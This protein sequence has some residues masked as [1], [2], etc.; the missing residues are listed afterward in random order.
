MEVYSEIAV[1][2]IRSQEE[3]IGPVAIEQASHINNMIVDWE[4]KAVTIQ[5]NGSAA[6][7]ELIENY[8]SLFGQISVEVSKEAVG[9]L[10]SKL[11]A[12]GIPENLR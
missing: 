10:I 8:K 12:N 2:I 9:S 6:I 7:D 4:N 3:I 11:P 1:K 5:K